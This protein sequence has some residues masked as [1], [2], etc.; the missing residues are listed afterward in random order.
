MAPFVQK[1]KKLSSTDIVTLNLQNKLV[2]RWQKNKELENQAFI[3]YENIK[4]EKVQI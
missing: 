1:V 4:K 3:N 2:Q